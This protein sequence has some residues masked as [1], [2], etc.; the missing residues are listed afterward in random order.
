[1]EKLILFIQFV[2]HAEALNINLLHAN[3]ADC[4]KTV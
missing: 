4:V 1:M 2:R 3:A